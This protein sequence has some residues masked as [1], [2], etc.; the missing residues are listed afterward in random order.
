MPP[1]TTSSPT[2]PAH[3]AGIPRLTRQQITYHF[4]KSHTPLLTVESGATVIFETYDARTGTI[5]RDSDLLDHPPPKGGNPVTGPIDIKGAEPG[6]S[7]A[8]EI[9][10]IRLAEQGFVAVKAGI[11]LLA[12]RA[13]RYATRVVDVRDGFVHYAVAARDA[14]GSGDSE[15][16]KLPV[17]PM[18]GVIGCAPAGEAI[19]SGAAGP[20]G[21]NMDNRYVAVGATVHLP[22]AVAG[23]RFAL[24]DIHATM[25]DGEI[26]ML[27]L[28]ICAEVMVR[29]HLRKGERC[30][31]PWIENDEA[32]ITT[33]DH[34]DPVT[35]M[36]ISVEEMVALLQDKLG[37]GFDDA[38]MLLSAQG[39]VN[40][41]QMCEPGKMAT[42]ARTLFP[43][44]GLG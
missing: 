16:I 27:G 41:C 28:E 11:G 30:Y 37:V 1:H 9:L 31:R 17:R 29:I 10:D 36:R 42:T 21:G 38:Y 44:L 25:G 43:K 40:I 20:H 14:D 19:A 34:L 13:G 8:V 35:A 3:A 39:D 18:I 23:A 5:T 4:D 2:T 24:G 26:T 6:D 32:W 15:R 22:I 12:D 7:L 33:G